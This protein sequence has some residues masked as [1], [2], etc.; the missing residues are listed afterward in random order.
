[1]LACRCEVSLALSLCCRPSCSDPGILL[2][3]RQ[4]PT[5]PN[6]KYTTVQAKQALLLATIYGRTAVEP[7]KSIQHTRATTLKATRL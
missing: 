2:P 7:K 1:L 4:A 6:T 3:N 5:P